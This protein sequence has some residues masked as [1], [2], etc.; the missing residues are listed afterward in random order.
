[1]SISPGNSKQGLLETMERDW[2][3][4]LSSQ[5]IRVESYGLQVAEADRAAEARSPLEDYTLICTPA[6]KTPAHIAQ[7]P[8]G[9][10]RFP[11]GGCGAVQMAVWS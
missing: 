7:P 6:A 3:K 8:Q 9:D 5:S 10:G 11:L 4:H 2:R 1:M